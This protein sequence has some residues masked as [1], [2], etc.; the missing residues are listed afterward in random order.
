MTPPPTLFSRGSS[1]V[2]V[3]RPF[4]P[5]FTCRQLSETTPSV[6]LSFPALS[7]WTLSYTHRRETS[8]FFIFRFYFPSSPLCN[9]CERIKSATLKNLAEMPVHPEKFIS[10]KRP[11]IIKWHLISQKGFSFPFCIFLQILLIIAF[12]AFEK[13]PFKRRVNPLYFLVFLDSVFVF[14]IQHHS[15]PCI[16]EYRV[17]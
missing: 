10:T 11:F 12:F 14:H 7:Y 2:I 13:P 4:M 9:S 17:L 8:S 1:R 16:T 15:V 6:F 3:H 5:P